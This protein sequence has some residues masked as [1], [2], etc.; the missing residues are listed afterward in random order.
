MPECPKARKPE[1]PNAG[2]PEQTL[3]PPLARSHSLP[4]FALSPSKGACPCKAPNS[5]MSRQCP[6][7]QVQCGNKGNE[8]EP[9]AGN[10]AE[11]KRGEGCY[12]AR[13]FGAAFSLI[14]IVL[15]STNR[16]G[17]TRESRPRTIAVSPWSPQPLCARVFQIPVASLPQNAPPSPLYTAYLSTAFSSHT[18]PAPGASRGV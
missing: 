17:N 1:C 7:P 6:V 4:P 2:M 18:I 12:P 13:I 15:S 3:A 16:P 14:P 9:T 10:K 8:I 11:E 5:R